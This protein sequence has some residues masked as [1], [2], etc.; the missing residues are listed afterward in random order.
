[1]RFLC[2]VSVGCLVV[3]IAVVGSGC[4][5]G[6]SPKRSTDNDS[7]AAGGASGDAPATVDTPMAGVDVAVGPP[8]M[9][10]DSV[11]MHHKNPSRDGVYVQP[12]LTHAAAAGLKLD[13]SFNATFTG[14]VY[15]QPLFVD[16]LGGKDLVIVATESD[17]I[18]AFDAGSGAQVWMTPLGTP[19]PLAKMPCGNIDLYGVTGTP[20]I[21][22]ASRTLFVDAMVTPDDGTTKQHKVFALSIDDGSMKSGWPVDIA[23]NAKSGA[24]TFEAAPQS[25]R[26]ALAIV[27]GILYLPF[28]GLYGDCG[29]Y[30]GWLVAIPIAQPTQVQA[31]ATTAR[32]GGSWGPS[33]VAS[34]G[35]RVFITTGNTTGTTTWGGGE[36]LVSFP[37]TAAL[38]MAPSYWAPKN[39]HDLD[40]GDVDLGG[41]APVIVDLPGSTPSHLAVAF[42]KDGNV[43]LEDATNLGGVNDAVAQVHA[44]SNEIITAAVIY[45]TA[46]ATYAAFKGNG[47]MCTSGS[48]SL[49]TVKIVP[50]APPAIMGSWCTSLNGFGSPIVTT[51]DGHADPIVWAVGAGGNGLL[52]GFDGDTGAV[53]YNGGGNKIAN[54][55]VYNAP[56]VAKGRIFVATDSAVVAFTP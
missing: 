53:V 8:V 56:I 25:Q 41:T 19:V 30:H 14:A 39:W 36:A 46:T 31:W 35:A 6:T 15:A 12:A 55:R 5:S 17:V 9:A 52:Q 23:A 29:N 50:G 38:P 21:D 43:Y 47:T 13:P 34:D 54:A 3:V 20:V 1:M 37:A 45:T 16:G 49:T 2:S 42:G 27:N 24:T 10:G 22:F 33:G 44:A 40:N 26:G 18:Y 4:K 48:G 32:A 11:L 51:T 28:G 7:G